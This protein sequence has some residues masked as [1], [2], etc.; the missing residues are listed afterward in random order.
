MKRL[1]DDNEHPWKNIRQAYLKLP[2]GDLIFHRN[3]STDVTALNKIKSI[4]KFFVEILKIWENFSDNSSD[5]PIVLLSESLWLNRFIRIENK[6]VFSKVLSMNNINTAG[7][8]FDNKGSPLQFQFLT[9]IGLPSTIR[10]FWLQLVNAIPQNWKKIIKVSCQGKSSPQHNDITKYSC[11]VGN[12]FKSIHTSTSRNFYSEIVQKVKVK[13]TS[14]KYFEKIVAPQGEIDWEQV[15]ML[16]RKSTIES[17][18][19][20]FQFKSFTMFF[21]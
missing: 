17:K 14:V 7:D 19:R 3:F 15:H 9:Q 1:R 11:K 5:D 2:I 8:I 12:T 4:P 20:S 13:A 21:F 16:P 10:F 18:M 6:S